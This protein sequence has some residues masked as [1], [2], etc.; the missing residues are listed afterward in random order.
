[1]NR[2]YYL[3][4]VILRISSK[5][6]Q[7]WNEE[8]P[9]VFQ[10]KSGELDKICDI[11]DLEQGEVTTPANEQRTSQTKENQ[12]I[13][14]GSYFTNTLV[15]SDMSQDIFF[16]GW[17]PNTEEASWDFGAS[18]VFES[19]ES[20]TRDYLEQ[21]YR[22]SQGIP[23]DILETE[24]C[25][26]RE[27]VCEDYPFFEEIYGEEGTADYVEPLFERA[28][29]LEYIANY[30]KNVY[31]YYGYGIW[32]VLDKT[33]GVV[34]GRIGLDPKEDGTVHLGY[35]LSRKWQ[36]L[37]IAT[38]VCQAVLRYAKE[39]LFLDEIFCVV[40]RDNLKGKKLCTRLNGVLIEQVEKS[41]Y[42]VIKL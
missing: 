6:R 1:M 4:K 12:S 13:K 27:M 25:V 14:D 8:A 40:H 31:E 20:L 16:L 22:R 36:Q 10:L 39:E 35:L 7:L 3:K 9:S 15:I 29:E 32:T 23:W 19:P 21:V 26:L 33:T 30:R 5:N 37:G 42:F 18:F 38:E 24:R 28:E 2:T 11:D 41:L 17:I 34:I